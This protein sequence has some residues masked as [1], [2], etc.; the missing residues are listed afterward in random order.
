MTNMRMKWQR[1]G[2]TL[3]ELL[4]VIAIIGILVALLLPAVQQAREAARRIQ[5]VNQ[6]RQIGLACLLHEEAQGFFPTGGWSKEWTGDPDRGYGKS[7]PGGWAYSVLAYIEETPTRELGKGQAF[8]SAEQRQAMDQLH[9]TPIAGFYC[10]SRRAPGAYPH[11]WRPV[12]NAQRII[13]LPGVVKSDYAANGGDGR[14]SAGDPPFRI[15]SLNQADDPNF[16]WTDVLDEPNPA[17]LNAI[18]CSGMMFYRSEV[19]IRQVKDGLSKTYLAGEK[20]VDPDEYL[21]F[22]GND[23]GEN[24]SSY[25]GFEWDNTRLTRFESPSDRYQPSRDTPGRLGHFAFGSAHTS[26]FNMVMGDNSVNQINFDVDREVHRR[27]GNRRDRLPASL[28][29]L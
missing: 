27:L 1:P 19:K 4:V 23:F 9:S 21:G 18:Y 14:W 11:S 7:Q 29:D 15:P 22:K 24:Q 3:V 12:F 20:H 8:N 10:P 26:G 13:G 2:F 6:L 25:T 16:P 28:D 17:N 5:C